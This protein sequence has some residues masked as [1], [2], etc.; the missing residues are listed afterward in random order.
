MSDKTPDALPTVTLKRRRALPFFSRHPWVFTGAIDSVDEG[1]EPGCEVAVRSD[2]GTFIARGLFNPESNIRVRLYS[3]DAE[4]PLD[5][6]FWSQKLDEA[7]ALRE[8]LFADVPSR[9][10]CRLVFSEGDGLSGLTVDRYGDW[11]LVQLTSLALY[12]RRELLVELLQSKLQPRGIWLR[13]EKGIREAEGLV[14]DDG[15]IAGEAPP[16]PLFIEE[17]GLR[18][19]VDVVEG[20]KTG[21]YFDQRDNRQAIARYTQG[22]RVLDLHCYTGGFGIAAARSGGA[23]EVLGVDSSAAAITMAGENAVMNEVADRVHFEKGDVAKKLAELSGAGESYDVVILDPPKMARHKKGIDSA[24]KA[25]TA[26]N[27]EAMKVVAP[28]GILVTCSCSG[29]VGRELF[30]G[31]V[32]RAAL[33]VDRSV[34]LLESRGQASDHPVSVYCPE[35]DYLTCLICRVI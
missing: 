19:G 13:T 31:A 22:T 30:L 2:D 4:Q 25:Y 23:R 10:A 14:Q 26:L 3:W 5:D 11:L 28:G 18:F 34:Q 16:R 32:T 29:L 17:H 6:D 12:E 20:Q 35:S 24:L 1:V 15:L 27:R 33:Q 8:R 9:Q 21:Y 7:I